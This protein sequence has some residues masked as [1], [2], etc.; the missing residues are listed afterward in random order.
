M[1]SKSK[2]GKL[3]PFRYP[4]GVLEDHS[5]YLYIGIR[6]YKPSKGSSSESF[7]IQS[8][9]QGTSL[10][11]SKSV[12]NIILP[13][14]TSISASNGVTWSGASFNAAEKVLTDTTSAFMKAPNAEAALQ[15]ATDTF[16]SGMRGI[17]L[18]EEVINGITAKFSQQIIQQLGSSVS[19]GQILARQTGQV[20]NP[21]LELLFQGPG[22]RSFTFNYQLSPR[23]ENE[24]QTVKNI[25]RVLKQSMSPRR[26]NSTAFLCSPHLFHLSFKKGN[27]D[28]PYLNRFKT[29]ACTNVGVVYTG[30]GTYATYE[31][32]SPVVYNLSLTF[33]ELSPIYNEDYVSEEGLIGAGY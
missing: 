14:P 25:L 29:M 32:G 11:Q 27:G 20:L 28:H 13:I 31:D 15:S 22:L 24:A 23:D 2:K 9:A 30:T 3:Q 17:G 18:G 19:F 1:P 33:Q 4:S 21:N 6:S 8:L 12:A 7:R 16:T 10:Q 5:D 26:G